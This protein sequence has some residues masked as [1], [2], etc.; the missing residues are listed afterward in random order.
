LPS[1]DSL[2]AVSDIIVVKFISP[3]T[4]CNFRHRVSDVMYIVT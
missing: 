2:A 3:G 1:L 4:R